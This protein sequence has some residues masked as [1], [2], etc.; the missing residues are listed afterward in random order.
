MFLALSTNPVIG[1][2]CIVVFF[3]MDGTD[4]INPNPN[5]DPY[6]VNR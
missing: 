3:T 6:E 1:P 5:P 4:P 2:L